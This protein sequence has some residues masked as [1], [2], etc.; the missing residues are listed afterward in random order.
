VVDVVF[1]G[2]VGSGKSSLIGSLYRAINET[3]SFPEK[4][5]QVLHHPDEDSHGTMQW[6]E[7]SGT[8]SGTVVYQDTRGDQVGVDSPV[9]DSNYKQEE[10]GPGIGHCIFKNLWY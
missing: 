9:V 10:K 7:T 1:I 8:P 5:E 4:V 2:P 3:A 6:L